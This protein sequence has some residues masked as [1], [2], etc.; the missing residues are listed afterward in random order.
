MRVDVAVWISRCAK[1]SQDFS[2]PLGPDKYGLILKALFAWVEGHFHKRRHGANIPQLGRFTWVKK[3]PREMDS[4]GVTRYLFFPAPRWLDRHGLLAA[5]PGPGNVAPCSDVNYALLAA[6]A[7][8]G[9]ALAR[10]ARST[11]VHTCIDISRN[12]PPRRPRGD[13]E[14]AATPPPPWNGRRSLFERPDL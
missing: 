8:V 12:F 11:Y 2:V 6:E 4:E 5:R 9:K 10:P 13:L 3:G 14:P 1:Q 7:G